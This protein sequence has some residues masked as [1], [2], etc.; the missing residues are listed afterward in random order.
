MDFYDKAQNTLQM[1]YM[2]HKNTLQH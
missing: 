1:L 2:H